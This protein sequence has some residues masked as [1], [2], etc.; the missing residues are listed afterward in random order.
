M[1]KKV[2]L[3]TLFL[4]YA[5]FTFSQ[6]VR[7]TINITEKDLSIASYTD[8][9]IIL[10]SQSNLHLTAATKSLNNSI[11]KLNTE[12][13]WIF[14]D[15][16]KPTVVIDSLLKYIYINNQ[17]AVLKTNVRVSIYKHGTVVIPQSSTYKPLKVYADKNFTGDS[18]SYSLFNFNNV[19]GIFNNKIR[20]F[21]LKRG[22]MATLAT[23]SDGTG[24]SRVYIADDQDLEVPVMPNL[25]DKSISF[26]R[27]FEW[28]WVSKKGWCSSGDGWSKEI[29]LT[30]STWYYSW[31]AD[32]N[33]RTNQEYVPIRQNGG[34]P[35]WSEISGKQY[36]THLLGF[37]EPDH[38]E[39]S[40]LTVAQAI[41]QWPDMLKSGLRVG[42]PA[43]TNTTWLYQFM[44][45][46]KAKN[47]R[48]DYVAYHAYWGGKSPSNWYNDLKSIHE[49]TG[50][51]IWLTEWNNGANWTTEGGWPNN[52]RPLLLTTGNAAKQL[53]DLKDILQVLDTA[54]FIER[55]SL[56]NW[57]EDARAIV[58]GD[59]LTPAG[60]YYAAD[61][62]GLAFN[63]INEVI[64][65]YKFTTPTLAIAFG[66]NNV[67]LT[68]SDLNL[69]SFNGFIVEKKVGDNVYNQVFKYEN[70]TS[71]KCT[72]TLDI[73]LS[74]KVRYRI[75]TIFMDGS[76]SSYSNEVGF[77]VTNGNDIQYGNL[78]LSNVGWNPVLFNKPFDNVNNVTI[79][80]GSL[81]NINNYTLLTGRAN[82]YSLSRFNL[83]LSPWAYQ[84]VTAIASA[85]SIPYFILNVGSYDFGGLKAIAARA[86]VASTWTPVTFS[87]PFDTIPVVFVSQ[88]FAST[89]NATSVRIR[90]V[91]ETGFEARL[92][93]ESRISTK[94][95]PE[96][97]SYFAIMPGIGEIDNKKIIVA[98][99]AANAV[100][101]TS[102]T[103]IN[104]GDSIANP[105][106]ISQLQTCNDDTVTAVLRRLTL[107]SK[108]ATVVKQRE[109]SLGISAAATESAGWMVINPANTTPQAVNQPFDKRIK[110]YPNPVKDFIYINHNNSDDI[111]VEIYDMFGVL[112][113]RINTEVNKI[114]IT[115]LL[116]GCYI[117]KTL[118]CESQKFIKI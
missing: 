79:I 13:S 85:E 92:Q 81:S 96:V 65:A 58:L 24:Y 73:N 32:K 15:N 67:T 34:W 102:V 84:N 74:N 88:I 43:V 9:E 37:N 10:N 18:A 98:K 114:S 72:D 14:F 59:S 60:K 27:V 51:P 39:Q 45:S 5:S 54:H 94:L 17:V 64:P 71:K 30:N 29:E 19:L 31:S 113:K 100:S 112:I 47:Y 83:Q 21:K 89:T 56:Y 3:F 53:A 116:P 90:N 48:V 63:K 25:L 6:N 91:T 106:F 28:E 95:N 103:T 55:Y 78:S 33:S 99:T 36:V 69:E 52:S 40:N 38:T 50:R 75:R 115:E 66:T 8:K 1:K 70:V 44:D 87:T 111:K 107:S 7:T 16:I 76:M 20:S 49:K 86:T 41:Q 118:N 12:N 22:Y 57:V 42:S 93:K 23:S 46:C 108:F 61:R 4:L 2:T 68:V 97:V 105:I 109:K 104:Y 110:F 80:L 82:L 62:P 77:D 35:S 101:T 11:V 117:L 26:M